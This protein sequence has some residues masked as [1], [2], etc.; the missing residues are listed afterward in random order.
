M[1]LDFLA[2]TFF[3]FLQDLPQVLLYKVQ[4]LRDT[5]LKPALINADL[6]IISG[7]ACLMSEIGQAVSTRL[8]VPL[9]PLMDVHPML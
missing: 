2:L 9:Y 7:L 1:C 4:F 8:L 6:K 3:F 5:L